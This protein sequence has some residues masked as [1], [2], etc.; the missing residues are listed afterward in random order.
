MKVLHISGARAWGGNEQQMID[1]IPQLSRLGAENIVFGVENSFLEEECK[2]NR[3]N[4]VRAKKDRLNIFA[5]YRYLKTLVQEIKPDLIHLHTSNS[6][7]VFIISNMLFK[8]NTKSVFSKKGMGSKS[9]FFSKFKY[10]YSGLNS[11]ICVSK[12]VENEFSKILTLKNKSKIIV[13]HDCVSLEILNSK[14]NLNL[15]E[16]FSID[17]NDVIVGNIANHTKAKDLETFIN[18]VDYIINS[19]KQK[20]IR[21]IQIG[22]FSDLTVELMLKVKEKKLEEYLFFTDKIKNANVLNNQ[23]DVFLMTS[24]REGGPTSILEAMLIGVPVVTTN[25]GVL[26]EIIVDGENGFM[27][28]VKD[29][30]DLAVK[31]T[32]L[33]SKQSLQNKFIEI[34]KLKIANEFNSTV[35]ANETYLAYQKIIK[36]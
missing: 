23:F 3:I 13:I 26:P 36:G 28:S 11:I 5:N 8:L 6:L 15:R 34:N 21:F 29:Y 35:I 17:E 12:N 25:V 30:K 18:T 9:S 14:S 27:S 7:T 1:L 10:N 4:F 24:E 16:K 31:L 19:L 33:I 22:Q 2:N 20:N 32:L